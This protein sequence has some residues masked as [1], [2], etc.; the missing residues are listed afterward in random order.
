MTI[1]DQERGRRRTTEGCSCNDVTGDCAMH[2]R[3]SQHRYVQ[4][5][6]CC[7]VVDALRTQLAE[8]EALIAEF[9][10]RA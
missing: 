4:Q 9:T 3:E 10:T 1:E 5:H 7:T 6:E 2:I 8:C